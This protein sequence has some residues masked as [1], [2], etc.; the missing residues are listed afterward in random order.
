MRFEDTATAFQEKIYAIANV[1]SVP[2][3]RVWDLWRDYDRRCT[4]YDQSPVLFEFVQ[5]YA[6]DLGGN[7]AALQDAVNN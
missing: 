2:A 5:W 3:L 1:S 6:G 4:G 7:R